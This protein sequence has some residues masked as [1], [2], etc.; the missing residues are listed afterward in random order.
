M[1]IVPFVFEVLIFFL[2]LQYAP[3]FQLISLFNTISL[4]WKYLYMTSP[5]GQWLSRVCLCIIYL[6]SHPEMQQL[7]V[8]AQDGQCEQAL[9]VA[10]AT[11][12]GKWLQTTY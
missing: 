6:W 1:T 8:E 11:L 12:A 3:N 5:V 10:P 4:P 9:W 7:P 2:H